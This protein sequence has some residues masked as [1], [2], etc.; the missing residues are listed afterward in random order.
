MR[1]SHQGITNF[2][3]CIINLLSWTENINGNY[4]VFPICFQRPKKPPRFEARIWEWFKKNNTVKTS[5]FCSDSYRKARNISP[6]I[7]TKSPRRLGKGTQEIIESI[8]ALTND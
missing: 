5:V 1:I 7:I 4:N 2:C 6:R 3:L 8:N